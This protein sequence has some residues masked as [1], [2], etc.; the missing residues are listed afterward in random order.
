MKR[1]IEEKG[2]VPHSQA[3]FRKGRGTIDNMYILD[4]LE[5]SELKKKETWRKKRL[6]MALIQISVPAR[7]N[8]RVIK[9]TETGLPAQLP[10]VHDILLD[11]NSLTDE[12]R[13]RGNERVS[14]RQGHGYGYPRNKSAPLVGGISVHCVTRQAVLVDLYVVDEMLRKA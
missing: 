3:G 2:V 13:T 7:E 14:V 1:E 12:M 9:G 5:K 4:H 6:E 11:Q 10:A 8:Y